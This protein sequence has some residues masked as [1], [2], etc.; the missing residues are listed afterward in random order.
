MRSM[1]GTSTNR[2]SPNTSSASGRDIRSLTWFASVRWSDSS[3][4]RS[5][6]AVASSVL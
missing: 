1:N 4:C 6:R 2:V 5:V 3:A